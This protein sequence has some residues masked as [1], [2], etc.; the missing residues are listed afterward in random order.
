MLIAEY[1]TL[2][3]RLL[4]LVYDLLVVTALLFVGGFAA[5]LFTGG[6]AVPSGNILFQLWLVLLVAG[7]YALSWRKAGQTMGM[8]SWRLRLVSADGGPMRWPTIARRLAAGALLGLPLIGFL[9][10]LYQSQ[11]QSWQ[12]SVGGTLTVLLS[13]D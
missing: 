3:R 10:C 6:T 8:R 11:R 4:A 5:M 13:K 7:Y 1:P 2:W 12:D 9:G